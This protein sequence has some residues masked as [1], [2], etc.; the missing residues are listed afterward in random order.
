MF[1]CHWDVE[2]IPLGKTLGLIKNGDRDARVK[3]DISF[4]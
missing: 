2:I 1:M 3:T 4:C